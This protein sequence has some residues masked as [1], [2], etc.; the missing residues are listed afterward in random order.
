M[1]VAGENSWLDVF[2]RLA[3]RSGLLPGTLCTGHRESFMVVLGAAA[4]AFEFGRDYDE[5]EVNDRLKVWLAGPGSMLATDHVTLRRWLVDSE[6]L[7]RDGY[8]RGY[9]RCEPRD[10]WSAVSEALAGIDLEAEARAARA[11]EAANRAERKAFW[12]ART[13]RDA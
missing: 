1:T 10:E 4:M 7:E 6:V 3:T 13:D 2:R 8:G 11:A 5:F 9:R 12:S